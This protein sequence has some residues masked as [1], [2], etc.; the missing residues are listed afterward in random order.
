M[1]GYGGICILTLLRPAGEISLVGLFLM[2]EIRS[3]GIFQY[4]AVRRDALIT[5]DRRSHRWRYIEN[6]GQPKMGNC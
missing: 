6:D 2:R 4:I 3:L 5:S 1:D